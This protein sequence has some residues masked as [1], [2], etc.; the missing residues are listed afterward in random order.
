MSW[1]SLAA[2][3]VLTCGLGLLALRLVGLGDAPFINDEPQFLSAAWAQWATGFVRVS[4][5]VG[6]T[7]HHYG[8]SVLWLYALTQKLLGRSAL[9]AIATM[10]TIVTASQVVCALGLTVRLL[11]L[12]RARDV[13]ATDVAR[14][15]FGALLFLTGSSPHQHFW[16]RLAWDQLT[17]ALPFLVVGLLALPSPGLGRRVAIGALLGFA[18][19]SHPMVVVF[20]GLAAMAA[21]LIDERRPLRWLLNGLL[22]GVPMV[23]VNVPW[24][25]VFLTEPEGPPVPPAVLTASAWLEV[26]RAPS[27]ARLG[28]F[29]DQ[30]W[31]A[32][33]ITPL[34]EVGDEWLLIALATVTILGLL[35]ALSRSDAR[36]FGLM[37]AAVIVGYP[38]FYARRALVLQPHYQFPTG[39]VTIAAVAVL[40]TAWKWR[41]DRVGVPLTAL[42]VSTIVLLG[43]FQTSVLLRWRDLVHT[44]GGTRGIHYAAVLSEQ[45]K[46]RDDLC[47]LPGG[48]WVVFSETTLFPVALEYH[49]QQDERCQDKRFSLCGYGRACQPL[50]GASIA[51]V[52]WGEAAHLRVQAVNSAGR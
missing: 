39:W 7:A 23:L 30:E 9:M 15:T 6:S 25:S 5:L 10:C 46:V 33:H 51:R 11:G 32:A 22:V 42:G 45:L 14:A 2:W 21:T 52:T 44:N 26:F 40:L 43:T 20:A 48:S 27:A 34:T 47:A 37:G 28:Y 41:G 4:P 24:L 18:I 38:V 16:S 31:S 12:A 35:V 36:V 49:L 13:L 50:P 3:A 19:S 29:F 17:D 1:R 8:P